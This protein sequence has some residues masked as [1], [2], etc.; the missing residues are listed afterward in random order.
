MALA[1]FTL[2]SNIQ[3]L[4]LWS[5]DLQQST[6]A[7]TRCSASTSSERSPDG[8][9]AVD[10]ITSDGSADPIVQQISDIG[11]AVVNRYFTFSIWGKRSWNSD[12]DGVLRILDSGSFIESINITLTQEWQRYEINVQMTGATGNDV[13][14]R[15]DPPNDPDAGDVIWLWGAQLTETTD[16]DPYVKTEGSIILSAS[17]YINTDIEYDFKE[18]GQKIEDVH[19]T[20]DGARYRYLWGSFD[21][22]EFSIRYVIK[23]TKLTI[24]EWWEENQNV[25]LSNNLTSKTWKVHIVNRS[26]PV[27]KVEKPYMEL[28]KG[29]LI[30]ETYE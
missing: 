27:D 12:S 30:L 19:R 6:W 1:T 26:V 7:K 16:I 22:V 25:I 21:K 13:Y 5:E 17:N 4:L 3:N 10:K 20:K 14:V 2:A 8:E 29:K 28:Y 18:S 15:F 9:P 23:E 24:N 11:S